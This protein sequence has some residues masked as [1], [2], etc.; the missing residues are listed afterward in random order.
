MYISTGIYI[1]IYIYIYT[2]LIS[3]YLCIYLSLSRARSVF[4]ARSVPQP[5]RELGLLVRAMTCSK[6]SVIKTSNINIL[7]NI[8]IMRIKL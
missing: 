1:Y 2:Y 8:N 6:E 7:R 5:K 3:I 4:V